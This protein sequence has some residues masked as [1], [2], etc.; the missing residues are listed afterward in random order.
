MINK[1]KNIYSNHG[2]ISYWLSRKSQIFPTPGG[3]A[4]AEGGPLEM[5][6]GA[7]D[8]KTRMMGLPG[9]ERCFTNVTECGRQR[10]I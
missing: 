5:D 1:V 6:I 4:P 3:N 7:R 2:P 8:Q 9:R 10:G